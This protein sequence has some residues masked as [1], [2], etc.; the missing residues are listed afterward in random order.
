MSNLFGH[1]PASPAT[2]RNARTRR[3][4]IRV[5]GFDETISCRT[6]FVPKRMKRNRRG[7]RWTTCRSVSTLS[8]RQSAESPRIRP[9]TVTTDRASGTSGRYPKRTAAASR[10]LSQTAAKSRRTIVSCNGTCTSI[11]VAVASVAAASTRRKRMPN[12]RMRSASP[13]R[14]RSNS[15]A[16]QLQDFGRCGRFA[17]PRAIAFDLR[18]KGALILFET[19]CFGAIT[20]Q[21][22]RQRQ[23]DGQCIEKKEF[24]FHEYDG[25][26]RKDSAACGRRVSIFSGNAGRPALPANR[27][28]AARKRSVREAPPVPRRCVRP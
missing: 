20:T 18:Q 3:E 10:P 8:T 14:R 16:A 13:A 26:P 15:A 19:M 25:F 5:C 21:D 11:S 7:T 17:R 9:S 12:C 27:P 4:T 28:A 24:F 1:C 23:R 6:A 2:S 22:A